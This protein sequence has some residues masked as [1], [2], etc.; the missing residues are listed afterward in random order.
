MRNH[1]KTFLLI[2]F[3]SGTALATEHSAS[4]L[5]Q[6][7]HVDVCDFVDLERCD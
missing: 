6:A 7:P 4:P 2:A 3:F 5:P 1:L